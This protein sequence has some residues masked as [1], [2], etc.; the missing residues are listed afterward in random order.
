M[1]L[2]TRH[3]ELSTQGRTEIVDITGEVQRLLRE[4]G[5][6]EGGATIF[7]VGSTVGVTTMEFEPGLA[8]EDLP[9]AF[10]EIAPPGRPYA[11]H[12][13]WGDDNGSSHVRASLLGCSLV[14]PFLGARLLLGQ[15]QQI[16]FI[17]FDTRPRRRRIVVQFSGMR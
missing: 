1:E 6:A 14:V 15:W 16:V 9:A 12:A 2:L 17:D 3:L 7:A 5:F 13:T 10:N 11:H 8:K 4:S